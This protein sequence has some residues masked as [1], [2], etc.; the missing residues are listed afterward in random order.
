MKKLIFMLLLLIP[1]LSFAADWALST[2]TDL[3]SSAGPWI[4]WIMTILASWTLSSEWYT[5][6][7]FWINDVLKTLWILVSNMIYIIFAIMLVWVAFMNIIWREWDSYQF[8]SA[9]PKLIIWILSVPF[10]WYFVQIVLSFVAILSASILAIP[11]TLLTS[12]TDW[13]S[14]TIFSTCIYSYSET[15]KTN[16]DWESEVVSWCKYWKEV[17]IKSLVSSWVFWILYYYSYEI[18]DVDSIARVNLDELAASY[19][20][21][22]DSPTTW[23]TVDWFINTA[24]SWLSKILS[25]WIDWIFNLIIFVAYLLLILALTFA[26]M[27]RIIRLWLYTIFSPVFSLWNSFDQKLFDIKEFFKLA[28]VPVLVSWAFAFWWVFMIVLN[29]WIKE[30]EEKSVCNSSEIFSLW[31]F[32]NV[33]SDV[34][35]TLQSNI[36]E[37]NY[38]LS[39]SDYVVCIKWKLV[40]VYKWLKNSQWSEIETTGNKVWIIGQI[41]LKIFWIVILWM[42]VMAALR[43][44]SITQTVIQPI[45]DIWKN[46]ANTMK[47]LPMHVPVLPWNMSI[48][49][50]KTLS[51][52]PLNALR[53]KSDRAINSNQK[54]NEFL[55]KNF[56]TETNFWWISKIEEKLWNK[57]YKF[58]SDSLKDVNKELFDLTKWSWEFTDWN[59][60][61]AIDN[62]KTKVKESIDAWTLKSSDLERYWISSN[63]ARNWDIT[64]GD[65]K[66]II[67]GWNKA[68]LEA[69]EK[70]YSKA[71]E[72]SAWN[73]KYSG[74]RT[75]SDNSLGEVWNSIIVNDAGMNIQINLTSELTWN[76]MAKDLYSHLSRIWGEDRSELSKINWISSEAWLTKALKSYFSKTIDKGDS[77]D[78]SKI[79]KK[80]RDALIEAWIEENTLNKLGIE[81]K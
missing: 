58:N 56:D 38:Q 45:E 46:I 53:S 27:T 70:D 54:V 71:S 28:M 9:L 41:I 21:S 64:T 59:Y 1:Q 42:S 65:V 33:K 81:N 32:S 4:M 80:E 18:F 23:W 73:E 47:K 66:L 39:D 35:T 75:S 76:N 51:N 40:S 13:N 30:Q 62:Y 67:A 52:Y 49:S 68:K 5:W 77:I 74:I 8:K 48:S 69:F 22:I 31:Y 44:S 29:E 78:F 19:Q 34:K 55:K 17:E 63:R 16:T 37:S 24:W 60:K 15:A 25:I 12:N 36:K 50:Y 26:M 14:T 6:E 10:T 61:W 2:L 20:K 57:D 79:T 11:S 3:L 43:Y 72:D 7:I